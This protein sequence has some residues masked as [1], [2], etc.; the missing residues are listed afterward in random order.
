MFHLSPCR[1]LP[2]VVKL[3]QHSLLT[4]SHTRTRHWMF[5]SELCIFSPLICIPLRVCTKWKFLWPVCPSTLEENPFMLSSEYVCLLQKSVWWNA[6]P[7]GF[8]TIS[9]NLGGFPWW[10]HYA[11]SSNIAK[12]TVPSS[13][14]QYGLALKQN[15]HMCLNGKKYRESY[16]RVEVSLKTL[17]GN[18][19]FY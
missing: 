15:V 11:H 12:V 13:R 9:D 4:L 18:F 3:H 17:E 19:D 5:S 8:K 2:M 1:P 14:N 16:S 6:N 10:F 7:W